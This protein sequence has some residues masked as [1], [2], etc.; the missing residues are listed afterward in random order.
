MKNLTPLQRNY[1]YFLR[2]IDARH[3]PARAALLTIVSDVRAE[4]KVYVKHS[5]ANSL[6]IVGASKFLLPN[7]NYLRECYAN[8]SEVQSLKNAIRNRQ[9]AHLHFECQY[10]MSGSSDTFD[11]YIPKE[12][13]P[14]FAVLS[15]NLIP[16][17]PTC[18]SIKGVVWKD[19]TGERNI[20]NFYYD[21]I[22]IEQYLFCHITYRRNTPKIAFT[23]NN[24]T[25]I[26]AGLFH[27]IRR[28]YERLRLLT[29]FTDRSNTVVTNV[30]DEISQYVGQKTRL[31]VR[32]I[33]LNEVAKMKVSF[34][35]NFWKA[36]L[37]E[38]LANSNDF[39]ASLG[40]H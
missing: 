12:V 27:T 9:P 7:N 2:I 6:N 34:G 11:H 1:Y 33:I 18:N 23:I 37:R 16:C 29:R 14:E 4:Y 21:Q 25:G 40:F 26:D 22:P 35:N 20:I 17:C 24:A 5:K 10:C 8:T 39:L 31:E 32:Q 36:I 28:H 30:V 19:P 3:D 15:N 38:A 13:Y